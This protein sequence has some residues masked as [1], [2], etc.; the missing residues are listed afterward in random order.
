MAGTTFTFDAVDIKTVAT[1]GTEIL[2]NRIERPV[3]K[4]VT[5]HKVEIPGRAGSWDFGGGVA[6]D[7]T[8]TVQ[9]TI[10]GGNSGQVIACSRAIASALAGKKALIFGDDLTQSYQAQVYEMVMQ[11]Q[12]G[13]GSAVRAT[14]IFECDA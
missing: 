9:L 6:R 11:E 13:V 1:A 5:R 14:I 7:F 12:L 2:I 10:V 8:I 3:M 4:P